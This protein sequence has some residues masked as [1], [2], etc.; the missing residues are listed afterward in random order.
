MKAKATIADFTHTAQN[1]NKYASKQHLNYIKT[2]IMSKITLYLEE[3][4]MYTMFDDVQTRL[5]TPFPA[6]SPAQRLHF[7]MHGYVIIE[8]VFSDTEADEMRDALIEVRERARRERDTGIPDPALN[9]AKVEWYSEAHERLLGLGRAHE[10]IL[11]FIFNPYL[12][13]MAEE[14]IGGAARIN[15]TNG[16][17]NRK[18][19]WGR[20]GW[21][22]GADIQVAT[23]TKRNLFHCNFVKTLVNLTDFGPDDGGTVC[24]PG[25]HKIDIPSQQLREIVEH[26][27]EMIHQFV[28]PKGS[29]FL[30]AETLLHGTGVIKSD[31]ERFLLINGFSTRMMPHWDDTQTL[32]DPDFLETLPEHLKLLVSGYAHWTR[33]QRY[34]NI[35]DPAEVCE[36]ALIP[37]RET[38][39]MTY[40]PRCVD[41]DVDC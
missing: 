18:C 12:V 2:I 40:N 32:M 14:V 7:D 23:Y 15:E 3:A 34:R 21:H 10:R 28:A 35:A 24:I 31:T 6:L 4:L 33:G 16:H 41:V 27:P 1:Y 36:P 22:R 5:K 25:T 26:H 9:G 17:I 38:Q 39:A 30:F 19:D 20:T 29:V 37:W 8:N 11:D 13:G